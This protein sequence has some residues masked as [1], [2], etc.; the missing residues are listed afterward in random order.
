MLLIIIIAAC[1]NC[2]L[3]LFFA[4]VLSLCTS[5]LRPNCIGLKVIHFGF[6]SKRL[7]LVVEMSLDWPEGRSLNRLFNKNLY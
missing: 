1:C 7:P 6:E 5:L 4:V 3:M 2:L